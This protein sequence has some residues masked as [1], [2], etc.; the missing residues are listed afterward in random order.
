V[1]FVWSSATAKAGK[2]ISD[3]CLCNSLKFPE[4]IPSNWKERGREIKMFDADQV[5]F[6]FRI[7]ELLDGALAI[8]DY[9]TL[10]V[11]FSWCAV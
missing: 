4:K 5:C 10:Q 3:V 6:I 11:P 9:Y 8:V 1:Q 2:A 7:V